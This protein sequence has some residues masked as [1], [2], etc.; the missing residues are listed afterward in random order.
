[1]CQLTFIHTSDVELNK[2]LLINQY[3]VNTAVSHRDGW[4]FFT[5]PKGLFKTMYHPWE[6]SNI[7]TIIK[8]RVKFS[9]PIIAHVRLATATNKVKEVCNENSHPFETKD[10]VVAHNGTFDGDILSEER[11]KDKIDSEIFTILLQEAY[12]KNPKLS[13]IK[14]LE[15]AYSEN[16]TGKF[17]F[18]IYFKPADK[19]YIVRGRTAM[20]HKSDISEYDPETEK[21]KKIGFII[22]TDKDDIKRAFKFAAKNYELE[23]GKEFIISD[24]EILKMNTVYQVMGD[25]IK[26]IGSLL[27]KD[28]VVA[29]RNHNDAYIN[30]GYNYGR[31]YNSVVTPPVGVKTPDIFLVDLCDL[32]GLSISE[33]DLLFLEITGMPI[34][35]STREEFKIFQEIAESYLDLHTEHKGNLWR[36]LTERTFNKLEA[37]SYFDLQFPYFVNEVSTLNNRWI[38]EKRER[39]EIDSQN[40]LLC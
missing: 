8:D 39:E 9:E 13:I 23:T 15:K 11:F 6:T 5:K 30:N 3:L 25:Y 32:Y 31:R 35:A 16:L 1:M 12:D 2:K 27:E 29:A 7:G 4:G 34:I 37:Y 33:V 19:Y 21:S 18:L 10:F 36:K 14:L 24:P 40:K 20:L 28:K 22:N 38:K 26:E 17:A